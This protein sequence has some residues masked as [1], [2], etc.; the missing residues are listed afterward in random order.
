MRV[1]Q[2]ANLVE[3]KLY[4]LGDHTERGGIGATE[5]TEASFHPPGHEDSLLWF[6][7]RAKERRHERIHY[8]RIVRIL[9]L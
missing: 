2:L 7:A 5:T 9:S 4:E 1:V 8:V 6:L 3:Q